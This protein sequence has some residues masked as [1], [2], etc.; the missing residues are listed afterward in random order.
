MGRSFL[1]FYVLNRKCKKPTTVDFKETIL[2]LAIRTSKNGDEDNMLLKVKF[3][4]GSCS[5]S[6][7]F[8]YPSTFPNIFS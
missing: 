6:E 1:L 3:I 4:F 5:R 2:I 8:C 7:R